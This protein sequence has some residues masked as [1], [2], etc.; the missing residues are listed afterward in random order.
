MQRATNAG[1]K[2]TLPGESD[3]KTH[4]LRESLRGLRRV[5]TDTVYVTES[6]DG[7]KRETTTVGSRRSE[8]RAMIR[9]G[10]LPKDWLQALRRAPGGRPITYVPDLGNPSECYPCYLTFQH[11]AEIPRVLDD[12]E[13]VKIRMLRTDGGDLEGLFNPSAS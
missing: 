1:F 9:Y 4:P 2:Y 12:D 7:T 5:H 13:W 3:E 6:I 8:V 11:I 10:D